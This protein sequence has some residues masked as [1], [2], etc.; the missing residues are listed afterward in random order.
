MPSR[1]LVIELRGGLRSSSRIPRAASDGGRVAWHPNS[2]VPRRSVRRR[3]RV[4]RRAATRWKAAGTAPGRLVARERRG[5]PTI[6]R[7]ALRSASRNDDERRRAGQS[8][9]LAPQRR[10]SPV[11][12]R[13]PSHSLARLIGMVPWHLG[14][15]CWRRLA[16]VAYVTSVPPLVR[17]GLSSTSEILDDGRPAQGLALTRRLTSGLPGQVPRPA[18]RGPMMATATMGLG[19]LAL[20]RLGDCA[21]VPDG[22]VRGAV[23]RAARMKRCERH[24]PRPIDTLNRRRR[25]EASDEGGRA[26]CSAS[27]HVQADQLPRND[28]PGRTESITMRCP[29]HP[30]R[31]CNMLTG[32]VPGSRAARVSR[33][34]THGSP[35]HPVLPEYRSPENAGGISSR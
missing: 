5:S 1:A 21:R 18:G 33:S 15:V 17:V 2:R 28:R 25:G 31:L 8:T 13:L 16:T 22:G 19:H 9:R 29:V 6:T 30:E 20:T 10:A 27:A 24:A 23:P 32:V 3:R 7:E 34:P 14:A 35:D 4:P 26:A 11:A 12:P